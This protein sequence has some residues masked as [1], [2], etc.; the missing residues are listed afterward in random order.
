MLVGYLRKR[1][2]GML[3]QS[4]VASW[5]VIK[6]DLRKPHQKHLDYRTLGYFSNF[7]LKEAR[8]KDSH[9]YASMEISG[10]RRCRSQGKGKDH[11]ENPTLESAPW[12]YLLEAS[13][14]IIVSWNRL[15]IIWLYGSRRSIQHIIYEVVTDYCCSLRHSRANFSPSWESIYHSKKVLRV[16]CIKYICQFLSQKNAPKL[17]W[18]EKKRGSWVPLWGC[19]GVGEVVALGSTEWLG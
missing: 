16:M 7:L 14:F 8:Y 4:R 13:L 18:V 19:L 6:G 9:Y 1:S 15:A 10:P 2:S 12:G 5:Q 11:S 3:V 17:V